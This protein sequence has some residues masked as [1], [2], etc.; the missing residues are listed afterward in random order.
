MGR[1]F[2][3][4]L[5]GGFWVLVGLRFLVVFSCSYLRYLVFV[6]RLLIFLLSLGS[7]CFCVLFFFWEFVAWFYW[8][9]GGFFVF[10]LL[11]CFFYIVRSFG[12]FPLSCLKF[13]CHRSFVTA[14]STATC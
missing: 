4:F 1:G 6:N 13:L 11:C 12:V 10:R 5:V 8:F 3:V 7:C 9:I 14:Y 2:W